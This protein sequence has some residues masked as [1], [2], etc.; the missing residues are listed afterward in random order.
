MVEEYDTPPP[1]QLPGEYTTD[2]AL[3][4]VPYVYGE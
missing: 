4:L 2:E 3:L 1:R